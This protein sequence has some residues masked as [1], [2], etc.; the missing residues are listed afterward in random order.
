MRTSLSRR[1]EGFA[2]IELHVVIA[3][4]GVS[5]SSLLPAVLAARESA[6]RTQSQNNLK[7]IGIGL[8]N[9]HDTMKACPPIMAYQWATFNVP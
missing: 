7:Q 1:R 2:L 8:H 3:N 5:V 9:A 4:I 6:R